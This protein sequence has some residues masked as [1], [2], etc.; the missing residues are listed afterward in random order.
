MGETPTIPHSQPPRDT[1][2]LKCGEVRRD[3]LPFATPEELVEMEAGDPAALRQRFKQALD[4]INETGRLHPSDLQLPIVR[5]SP[6]TYMWMVPGY[7]T[8]GAYDPTKLGVAC[9]VVPPATG[10]G[11]NTGLG[12]WNLVPVSTPS[13]PS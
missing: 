7:G 6:P 1:R 3:T 11:A 5:G 9:I 13:L 2:H 10:L 8:G 12:D 4:R